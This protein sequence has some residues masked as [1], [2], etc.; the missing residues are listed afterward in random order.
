MVRQWMMLLEAWGL[1]HCVKPTYQVKRGFTRHQPPS[2]PYVVA[3]VFSGHG[4]TQKGK[5]KRRYK[6]HHSEGQT[7][8]YRKE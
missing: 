4:K 8:S 5:K 7:C 3:F 1:Q 6:T 2:E